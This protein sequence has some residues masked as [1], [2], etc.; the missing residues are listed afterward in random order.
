MT[1][2]HEASL[3]GIDTGH[4]AFRAENLT[5]L[6]PSSLAPETENQI[7]TGPEGR[8]NL[9]VDPS[10]LAKETSDHRWLTPNGTWFR[11]VSQVALNFVFFFELV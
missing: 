6:L 8:N 9:C 5:Q 10:G 2:E 3:E 1:N 7:A 4:V 11:L